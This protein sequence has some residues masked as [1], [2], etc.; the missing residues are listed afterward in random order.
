M[1]ALFSS[2][3]LQN[4]DWSELV[5]G[6]F[7]KNIQRFISTPKLTSLGSS[8]SRPPSPQNNSLESDNSPLPLLVLHLRRGDYE[9]HCNHLARYHSSYIGMVSLPEFEERD[10][11]VLPQVTYEEN[12]PEE[13]SLFY[14][15]HCYPNATQIRQRIRE[16]LHD[17]ER[18]LQAKDSGRTSDGLTPLAK[19]KVKKVY[20][21]SNG[22]REWLDEVKKELMADAKQSADN[23]EWEFAWSW[24]DIGSSRD[25]IAG[26]EEKPVLQVMDMY[27]GQ[28]AELFVGNGVGILFWD[29][30]CE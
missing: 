3:I 1:K 30:I 26:W 10:A 21:M 6:V 28:R 23:G 9:D 20:I 16:V 14:S 5:K 13:V 29:L 27:V 25:L 19:E 8:A 12:I 17:Y 7:K 24:D 15:K 22:N 11:L 18:V 4:W 2:P